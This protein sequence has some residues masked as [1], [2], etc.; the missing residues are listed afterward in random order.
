MVKIVNKTS[1]SSV[2][3]VGSTPVPE[4]KIPHASGSE[5]QNKIEATLE[6]IQERLSKWS[7]SKNL[8]FF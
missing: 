5:S 4:A 3:S 7:T 1:P 2:G 6:Q 8:F